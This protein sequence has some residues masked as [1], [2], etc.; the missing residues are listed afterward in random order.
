M[1][2]IEQGSGWAHLTALA[3]GIGTEIS[4]ISPLQSIVDGGRLLSFLSQ[5]EH[6]GLLQAYNISTLIDA[7]TYP[8]EDGYNTGNLIEGLADFYCRFVL[9]DALPFSCTTSVGWCEAAVVSIVTT[10]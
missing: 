10:I 7:V 5:T 9:V 4:I 1:S 3:S 6:V 2:V 8:D